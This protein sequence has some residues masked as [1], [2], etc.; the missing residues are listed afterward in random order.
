[1][2]V[3]QKYHTDFPNRSNNFLGLSF[4]EFS[5]L[6]TLNY[7]LL[8]SILKHKC[9]LSWIPK[10]VSN[11]LLHDIEACAPLLDF[12]HTQGLF[13]L[14]GGGS[15]MKDWLHFLH[16]HALQNDFTH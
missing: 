7:I 2:E 8:V 12:L 3:L 6:L 11:R 14:Q 15:V 1:M 4:T 13:R 9:S 16:V 5:L 10:V